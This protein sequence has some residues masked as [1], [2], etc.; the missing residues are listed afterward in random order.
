MMGALMLRRLIY[1]AVLASTGVFV[2]PTARAQGTGVSGIYIQRPLV[3]PD[4]NLRIDAGHRFPRYD[5]QFKRVFVR[6]GDD[7]Q[8]INPG[9]SYGVGRDIEVGIVLPFQISPNA[10]PRNPRAHVQLRFLEGEAEV[11]FL[12]VLSAGPW[13]GANAIVG[14]PVLWHFT[15]GARLDTGGFLD[16]R[17]SDSR[18]VAL[19]LPAQIPFQLMPELYAGP[20]VI[21]E[22]GDLFAASG[23]GLDLGAFLGYNLDASEGSVLD[24]YTR[25]RALH[26]TNG[27]PAFELMLGLEW[28][29]AL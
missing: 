18:H 4:N 3:L 17:F 26:V 14:V 20:E 15:P 10:D 29:I 13:G 11:G 1:C 5:A 22:V 2:A 16:L 9:V 6:D 28:Y 19:I 25:F 23:F 7:Q 24:L 21:M 12:G 8:Y 27:L